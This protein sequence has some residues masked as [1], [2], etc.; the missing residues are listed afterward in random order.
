MASMH[1]FLPTTEEY[2]TE[3]QQ[4]ADLAESRRHARF[5]AVVLLQRMTRGYLIRKHMAWLARNATV[6]QCAFRVHIARRAYRIALSEALRNKHA[7]YYAVAATRIQA[8]WRGHYSRRTQ[9]SYRSYRNWI[10]NVVDKG[11]K[12]VAE[13]KDFRVKSKE[14]NLKT[15]EREAEQKLA[16]IVFKLHHLLRT[17]AI[18]GVY[19]DHAT[20]ELSDF[21]KLLKSVKYTEYRRK[22]KRKY[23]KF[24][25][26]QRSQFSNKALFPIIGEGNDYWY[27]SLPDM[28]ELTKPMKEKEDTRQSLTHRSKVHKEPFLWRKVRYSDTCK[29]PF[30]PDEK[31]KAI[32]WPRDPR[33]CLYV[34]HYKP[35]SDVFNYVDYH[36]NALLKRKCSIERIK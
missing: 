26:A 6:I 13:V 16:F 27:L 34:Q 32:S 15:L 8:L 31:L 17:F 10:S 21:E 33:F 25:M 11:E 30:K 36:I 12:L 14:E 18:A 20:N 22:L 28:Y 4:R 3:L 19:S 24:V 23:D 35:Q 7:K 1:S 9:F 2:F 5:K 29:G